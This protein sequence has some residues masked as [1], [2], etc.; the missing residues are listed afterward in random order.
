MNILEKY[1]D[2]MISEYEAGYISG[3]IS[4]FLEDEI[5][6]GQKA[7]KRKEE[8]KQGRTYTQS[9]LFGYLNKDKYEEVKEHKIF[10]MKMNIIFDLDSEEIVKLIIKNKI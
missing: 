3:I 7:G 5:R 4:A 6:A 2:D 1:R 8:L 9:F 10:K